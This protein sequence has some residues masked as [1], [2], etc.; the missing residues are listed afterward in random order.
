MDELR[1]ALLR[2]W[3]SKG[4]SHP[5]YGVLDADELAATSEATLACGPRQWCMVEPHDV[6][7]LPDVDIY[8]VGPDLIDWRAPSPAPGSRA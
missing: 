6:M 1:V 4:F 7:V 5:V 2:N 3:K 8:A